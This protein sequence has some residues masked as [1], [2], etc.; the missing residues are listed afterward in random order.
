M[1]SEGIPTLPNFFFYFFATHTHTHTHTHTRVLFSSVTQQCP[2]L[3]YP[4]ES[5][6]PGLP[7]HHQLSQF[8]QTHVLWVGDAIQPSHPLSSL[9]PPAFSLSQ[10]QGLF[11]WVNSYIRWPKYWSFSFSISPFNEYSGLISLGWTDQIS[12]QSKGL[13]SVFSTTV[14]E[15]QFF[16]IQLCL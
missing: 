10:Q 15:H 5:S 4:M 11:Q 2:T 9:S 8:T 6:M 12:L 7:V 3:C 14:Q 1:W 13:S 16:G